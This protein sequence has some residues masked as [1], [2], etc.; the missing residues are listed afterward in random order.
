MKGIFEEVEIPDD[1]FVYD[2]VAKYEPTSLGGHSKEEDF[3]PTVHLEL[4]EPEI[5]EENA[6][7]I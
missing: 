2:K 3:D 6:E 1:Y 7:E 4:M 5:D